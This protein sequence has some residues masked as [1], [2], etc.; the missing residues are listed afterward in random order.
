[1]SAAANPGVVWGKLR[2]YNPLCGFT[3]LPGV[4]S[5]LASHE[6]RHQG[7]MRDILASDQFP[8]GA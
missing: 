6:R 5:F 7:Q 3:N 4:L 2:Y 1:M 8:T